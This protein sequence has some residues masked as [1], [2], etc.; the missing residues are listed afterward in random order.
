[1]ADAIWITVAEAAV[2]MGIGHRG[3]LKRLKQWDA[4]VAGRLLQS[5]NVKHMPN[6]KETS[7]KYLV[8]YEVLKRWIAPTD[9]RVRDVADYVADRR[10]SDKELKSH[11]KQLVADLYSALSKGDEVNESTAPTEFVW[12]EPG[13]L[14]PR[15]PKRKP[16][17]PRR[18]QRRGKRGP[19]ERLGPNIISRAE[20][21]RRLKVTAAAVSFA[22]GP[23]GHLRAACVGRGIDPSHPAVERWIAKRQALGLLDGEPAT[24]PKPPEKPEKP[25]KFSSVLFDFGQSESATAWDLQLSWGRW[26]NTKPGSGWVHEGG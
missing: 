15:P 2:M 21:S 6:G 18:G 1:M 20:M 5:M 24:Q 9:R 14:L 8:L 13:P 4:Q 10:A 16:S 12:P 3:A 26:K 11:A 25:E 7:S 22:C 19:I 17:P 23:R